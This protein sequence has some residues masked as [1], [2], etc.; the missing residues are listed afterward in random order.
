V[1]FRGVPWSIPQ[2]SRFKVADLPQILEGTG[3][4]YVWLDL[5][6]IPQTDSPIPEAL[7]KLQK[8]EISRQGAIFHHATKVV[9]WLNDVED[10]KVLTCAIE[11]LCF[12]FLKLT[13]FPSDN[14]C[15]DS[16]L[17]SQ[18]Y[19]DMDV[20]LVQKSAKSVQ[21]NHF[22]T[23]LWTLQEL[24]L[25]PDMLLCNQ[26]WSPLLVSNTAISIIDIISLFEATM[27][28]FD[29]PP[30]PPYIFQLGKFFIDTGLL[31][32]SRATRTGILAMGDK[33]ECSGRRAEAIMS[34]LGAT[35]WFQ[36]PDAQTQPLVLNMYPLPFL[37]EVRQNMGPANFFTTLPYDKDYFETMK[38]FGSWIPCRRRLRPVGSMLPFRLG[39]GLNTS[40]SNPVNMRDAPSV[41]TWSIDND[42]S[43]WMPSA[44]I[45][46][47]DAMHPFFDEQGSVVRIIRTNLGAFENS[48]DKVIDGYKPE[49][50]NYAICTACGRYFIAGI[51]L[52]EV[53]SRTILKGIKTTVLIK[54]G[55]FHGKP[56]LSVNVESF[57]RN[58]D[59]AANW[60]VL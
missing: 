3:S 45:A 47:T 17:Q 32:L 52:K 49:R 55:A 9:A 28:I 57:L 24:C 35:E 18:R 23:S 2:N 22:F 42:G 10:W 54:I 15:L 14:G 33:R 26:T 41:H 30:Q 11:W 12:R 5:L 44:C 4:D 6:C 25:R 21:F 40:I 38:K 27:T 56:R 13:G 46:P 8:K 48:I 50:R 58:Y 1:E 59:K 36:A 31:Q 16:L 20:E 39:A 37:Y 7:K 34:A 53:G 43:V 19:F 29:D 51:I 60:L